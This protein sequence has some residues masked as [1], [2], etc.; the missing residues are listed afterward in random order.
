MRFRYRSVF[1]ISLAVAILLTVGASMILAAP[2]DPEQVDREDA[3]EALAILN[4]Y[5]GQETGEGLTPIE[6]AV[7]TPVPEPTASPTP[8][9][10]PTPIPVLAGCEGRLMKRG[11]VHGNP[12]TNLFSSH[13]DAL[14]SQVSRHIDVTLPNPDTEEWFIGFQLREVQGHTFRVEFT[15]EGEWQV[16]RIGNVSYSSF[17]RTLTNTGYLDDHGIAF[18]TGPGEYNQLTFNGNVYVNGERVPLILSGLIPSDTQGR[19]Q[20]EARSLAEKW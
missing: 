16:S 8:L 17:S 7:S 15:N 12:Y 9:P 6:T 1:I 4:R 3:L 18:N 14:V 10:V 20:A 5:F 19:R 13:R 11:W 2:N